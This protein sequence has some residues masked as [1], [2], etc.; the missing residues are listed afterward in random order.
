[1]KPIEALA[2][3][4]KRNS[5]CSNVLFHGVRRRGRFPRSIEDVERAG[6]PGHTFKVVL[7]TQTTNKFVEVFAQSFVRVIPRRRHNEVES[8]PE[9]MEL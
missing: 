8:T 1:M 7:G 4:S 5:S 9:G 6:S 3:N 2:S